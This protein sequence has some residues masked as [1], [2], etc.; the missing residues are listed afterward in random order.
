MADIRLAWLLPSNALRAVSI[1]YSTAPK[2][3]RSVRASA[4][5]ASNCSGA[6]YWNVPKIVPGL[7]SPMETVLPSTGMRLSIRAKPKSKS[8]APDF[9]NMML[10]GFKSRCTTDLRCAAS[11]ASA[12]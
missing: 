12:I 5:F 2:A 1:S 7:V 11:R 3:N 10:A 6:M 8:L 9:V 4:S